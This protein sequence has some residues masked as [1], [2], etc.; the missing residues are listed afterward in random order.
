M[1]TINQEQQEN[2]YIKLLHIL[3]DREVGR[4]YGYLQILERAF[5]N[6]NKEIDLRK[7]EFYNNQIETISVQEQREILIKLKFE[8]D[9]NNEF[10]NWMRQ[11]FIV[12]IYSFMELWLIRDCHIM[13]EK[14]KKEIDNSKI[15][16]LDGLKSIRVKT[17]HDQFDYETDSDWQWI[18]KLQYLRNYITHRNGSLTGYS[19]FSPDKTLT[20][21]INDETDL[22]LFGVNN[23]QILIESEFCLKALRII[24]NLMLKLLITNNLLLH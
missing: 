11:S 1:E 17:F 12:S 23:D 8:L 16:G 20:K 4:L 18:K 9:Q 6:E 7:E 19:N 24:H 15:R 13:I 14:S 2:L 3:I 10:A 5:K 21:F 22:S